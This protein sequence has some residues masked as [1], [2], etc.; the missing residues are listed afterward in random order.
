[1]CLIWLLQSPVLQEIILSRLE[2]GLW[3]VFRKHEKTSKK[4]LV[5][6]QEMQLSRSQMD[7]IPLISHSRNTRQQRYFWCIANIEKNRIILVSFYSGI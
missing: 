4:N 1:M 6:L 2:M 7:K 3:K 5:K